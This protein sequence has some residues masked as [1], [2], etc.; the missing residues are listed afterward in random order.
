MP[1]LM[2]KSCSSS[3]I[4]LPQILKQILIQTGLKLLEIQSSERCSSTS[5]SHSLGNLCGVV[6]E[7]PKD[8]MIKERPQKEKLLLVKPS[9]NT[10][11][12]MPVQIS[13]CT[14]NT[15]PCWIPLTSQWCTEV[16][17]QFF[18]QLLLSNWLCS[19]FLKTSS[20]ITTTNNHQLMMRS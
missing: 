8:G 9:S 17:C 5:I 20:S 11:T 1:I 15:P 7:W 4:G 10:L 16:E 12:F 2:A 3:K 6:L 13:T 18:S 14:T 19:T